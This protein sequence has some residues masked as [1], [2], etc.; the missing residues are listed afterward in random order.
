M[1]VRE[2]ERELVLNQLVSKLCAAI[3]CMDEGDKSSI[4]RLVSKYYRGKG[5]EQ[6]WLDSK[7]NHGWTKDDRITFSVCEED[8]MDIQEMIIKDLEGEIDLDYSE[9][10]MKDVG[11][12]YNLL[13]TVRKLRN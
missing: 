7:H 1:A 10:Y 11:L 12:P 13:F 2:N 4:G 8:L 9:Y 6:H 3:R 5:Y